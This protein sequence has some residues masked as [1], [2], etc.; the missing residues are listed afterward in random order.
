MRKLSLSILMLFALS[1][2]NPSSMDPV[3]SQKQQETQSN[4]LKVINGTLSFATVDEFTATI[5]KIGALNNKEYALW[6]KSFGLKTLYS[7]YLALP[8][9]A[10][11]QQIA[12]SQP[13]LVFFNK[14]SNAYELNSINS[15]YAKVTNEKGL[16]IIDNATYQFSATEVKCIKGIDQ[17]AANTLVNSPRADYQLNNIKSS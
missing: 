16:V 7:K 10:V 5:K 3:D 6:Q 14:N 2:E 4:S 1:C 13:E 17:N 11:L 12:D 9:D 8:S 15:N